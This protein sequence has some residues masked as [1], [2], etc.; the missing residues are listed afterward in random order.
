MNPRARRQ[1]DGKNKTIGD[2]LDLPED[3]RRV[4]S[5]MQGQSMSSFDAIVNFLQQ[6]DDVVR[7]LLDE[8]QQQGFV[9]EIATDDGL[10]YQVRFTSMRRQRHQRE[11][12]SI[13]DALI[14]D[15]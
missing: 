15:D 4:L 7:R 9:R 8:L 5:W 2:L 13:F 6:S 3:K 14:D 12:K 10:Q 11:S 1:A